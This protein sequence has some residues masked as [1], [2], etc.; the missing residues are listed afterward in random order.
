MLLNTLFNKTI[1]S[2]YPYHLW[3][4]RKII[5][6]CIHHKKELY[7]IQFCFTQDRPY[8]MLGLVCKHKK[9]LMT[10]FFFNV[11]VTV[12]GFLN[13]GCLKVQPTF[14]AKEITQF[15]I[16]PRIISNYALISEIE[17][18]SGCYFPASFWILPLIPFRSLFL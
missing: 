9:G 10:Y 7:N 12:A 15:I 5:H 16:W 11:T 4:Q 8:K 14:T 2:I 6:T 17:T 13:L 3:Y 1:L 18:L